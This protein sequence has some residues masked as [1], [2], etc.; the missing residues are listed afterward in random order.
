[1]IKEWCEE[2][3][4]KGGDWEDEDVYPR[5]INCPDCNGKGYIER[6]VKAEDLSVDEQRRIVIAWTDFWETK[7]KDEP[8][9]P[10]DWEGLKK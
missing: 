10:E 1:M 4:G 2:C 3:D 6:E 9:S 5:F 8:Q 7:T